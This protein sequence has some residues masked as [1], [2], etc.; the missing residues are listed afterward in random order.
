MFRRGDAI[1][2]VNCPGCNTQYSLDE[3]SGPSRGGMLECAECGARWKLPEHRE[4]LVSAAPPTPPPVE[5][6]P[7]PAAPAPQVT[8]SA[9]IR[10]PV[11]CPQCGH[12]FIP[13]AAASQPAEQNN[14]ILI[15]EDQKYFAELTQDALGAGYETTVVSDPGGA[16]RALEAG[17]FDLV[18]LDLSLE[19]DQDGSQLLESIRSR[20][21]PVL[22]FTAREETDLYGGVWEALKQAGASD[23]L[24]K[25]MNVEETLRLKVK[26]LL[27]SRPA[28]R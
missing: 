9:R 15:V 28:R 4:S 14:R 8:S 17:R 5:A 24:L 18:I 13:G 25:G 7:E 1:M 10:K 23:I 16:R 21:L 2:I 22:I 19:G 3:R 27:A 6:G 12:L 11:N 20:Q 26:A